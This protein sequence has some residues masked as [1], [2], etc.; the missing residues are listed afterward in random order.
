[1]RVIGDCEAVFKLNCPNG[2]PELRENY[3][4]TSGDVK[5]I[6]AALTLNVA[7]LCAEWIRIHG[8]P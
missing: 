8:D 5:K 2:P 1:M 4:F 7:H 6:K 3:G